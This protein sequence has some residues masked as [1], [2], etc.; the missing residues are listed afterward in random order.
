[1]YG[2]VNKALKEMI[3]DRAGVPVWE[4]I[5]THDVFLIQWA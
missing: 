2:M 4:T 1:M 5:K 3:C